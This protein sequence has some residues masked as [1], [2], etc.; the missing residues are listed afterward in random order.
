MQKRFLVSVLVFA[1]WVALTSCEPLNGQ[2]SSTSDISLSDRMN[3]TMDP[4]L[5][6]DERSLLVSDL[7]KALDFQVKVNPTSFYGK[8]FGAGDSSGVIQYLSDRVHYLIP[9]S[10]D[11]ESRLSIPHASSSSTNAPSPTSAGGLYTMATN[12]GTVLWFEALAAAPS[13]LDFTLGDMRIPLTSSRVGIVQIGEGYTL[14]K[15]GQY[16]FPQIVRIATL[17][18]E[19]RHSD[20]TGGISRSDLQKLQNGDIPENHSCGHLHVRCPAGHDYEGAFACDG[21]AW[22]AYSIQALYAAALVKNCSNCTA[23]EQ[24]QALMIF[25]DSLNRV[26]PA[27]AMLAGKLGA[28]DMSSSTVVY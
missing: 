14:Q 2:I 16:A 6:S 13:E 28:P 10:A 27:E 3:M 1:S 15:N 12:V 9:E 8:A 17:V 18:H 24:N 20:C 11:L 25:S 21:E 22:G 4:A 26:I 7:N 19:A 5:T 23:E